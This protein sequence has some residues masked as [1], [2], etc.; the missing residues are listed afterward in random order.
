[1]YPLLITVM[2][3]GSSLYYFLRNSS[4]RGEGDVSLKLTEVPS[5]KESTIVEKSDGDFVLVDMPGTNPENI[6]EI[7]DDPSQTLHKIRVSKIKQGTIV[8]D[9]DDPFEVIE[10]SEYFDPPEQ[11]LEEVKI[12]FERM[13]KTVPNLPEGNIPGIV[14]RILEMIKESSKEKTV[15]SITSESF[16][17]DFVIDYPREQ[18]GIFLRLKGRVYYQEFFDEFIE[19]YSEEQQQLYK[20][21]REQIIDI[22]AISCF[23]RY[24]P[25]DPSLTEA[26]FEG[27]VDLLKKKEE[28]SDIFQHPI[29]DLSGFTLKY[30]PTSALGF[31]TE[32]IELHIENTGLREGFEGLLELEKLVTIF[33]DSEQEKLF[34]ISEWEE[35]GKEIEV[36]DVD[37]PEP[38]NA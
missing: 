14:D 36:V 8:G 13:L 37:N 7:P 38:V 31:F 34:D 4:N 5:I 29:I 30:L 24:N 9:P 28:D 20:D 6:G 22:A 23:N 10:L 21:F 27:I 3:A 1:M 33:I 16:S 26:M 32:A 17:S 12:Q 2:I 19:T 35:K 11:S 25:E 18:F 15:R